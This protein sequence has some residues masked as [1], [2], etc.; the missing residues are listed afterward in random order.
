MLEDMVES[1]S[2]TGS[3][4]VGPVGV[5]VASRIEGRSGSSLSMSM[6]ASGSGSREA[7]ASEY[8]SKDSRDG[9]KVGNG[10]DMM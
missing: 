5:S 1:V 9:G 10:V 2:M 3:R 7:L 8:S 4:V 6:S